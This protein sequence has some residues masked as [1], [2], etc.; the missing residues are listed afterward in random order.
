M[1]VQGDQSQTW[2]GIGWGSHAGSYTLVAMVVAVTVENSGL[3]SASGA[4]PSLAVWATLALGLGAMIAALVHRWVPRLALRV[5]ALLVGLLVTTWAAFASSGVEDLQRCLGMTALGV[6]GMACVP[7]SPGRLPVGLARAAALLVL[8][9]VLDGAAAA[10]G[11]FMETPPWSPEV[12]ARLLDVSPRSFV[13]EI[14]G[15]D[16]MRSETVYEPVGTD[17][18]PPMLRVPYRPVVA[19]TP[20]IVLGSLGLCLRLLLLAK[21]SSA[22]S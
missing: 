8:A 21:R 14:A 3:V 12:A 15:F 2:S 1:G 20:L 10:W 16:W 19:A 7:A 18:I 9:W 22:H 5:P 6:L 4:V 17:R 13:M 11:L